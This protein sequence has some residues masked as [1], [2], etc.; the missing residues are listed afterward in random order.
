VPPGE[1]LWLLYE[2]DWQTDA[3][4]RT[5]N[6]FPDGSITRNSI[7]LEQRNGDVCPSLIDHSVHVM[8]ENAPVE[9]I[10]EIEF[11]TSWAKGTD[12]PFWFDR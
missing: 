9:A 10:T 7:A 8:F 12:K 6:I 11:E 2:L 5:V 4:L 1:P 3:V